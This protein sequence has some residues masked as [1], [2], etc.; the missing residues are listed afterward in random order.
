[1]SIISMPYIQPNLHYAYTV[2]NNTFTNT[3]QL[4]NTTTQYNYK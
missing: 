1:M 3:I 2:H 4:H